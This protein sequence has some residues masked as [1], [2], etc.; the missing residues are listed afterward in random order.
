M[1]I[2]IQIIL[3]KLKKLRNNFYNNNSCGKCKIISIMKTKEKENKII[4]II[5]DTEK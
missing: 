5:K 4:I 2:N 3:F 1:I